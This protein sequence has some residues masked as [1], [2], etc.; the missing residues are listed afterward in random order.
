MLKKII[1]VR[2]NKDEAVFFKF[3][4]AYNIRYLHE[5]DWKFNPKIFMYLLKW[6]LKNPYIRVFSTKH[7]SRIHCYC[8]N[9][10]L[11]NR[12]SFTGNNI[13]L[14][15]FI[16]FKH[17]FQYFFIF[18]RTLMEPLL[19]FEDYGYLTQLYAFLVLIIRQFSIDLSY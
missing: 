12:K 8:P 13:Y 9:S 7:N 3:Y 16:I 19:S 6:L 14:I 4:L 11:E 1:L 10:I 2:S 5:A 17:F 18:L 15:S